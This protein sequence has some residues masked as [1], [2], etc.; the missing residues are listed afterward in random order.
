MSTRPNTRQKN[1]FYGPAAWRRLVAE[2]IE[3]HYGRKMPA[4]PPQFIAGAIASSDR[5]I[6]DPKV[7]FPWI[8]TARH[9]LAVEMESGGVYRAARERCPMLAIR[10]ISDIVGLK[11]ADA[12]TKYA[13]AAAAAFTRAYL[14][15]EPVNPK[16][17]VRKRSTNAYER[18]DLEAP[19]QEDLFLNMVKLDRLP[20]TVYVAP[21][22]C[23]TLKQ[24]WGI[25]REENQGHI[26][27]A[28][29]FHE[30]NIYSFENPEESG[31]SRIMD[32]S[33][34]ETWSVQELFNDP[35]K[36][37]LLVWLLKGA[38]RDDL[39]R[40]GV[41]FF[42]QDDV[43]AFMGF[44][45]EPDKSYTYDNL[46]LQSSITVVSHYET[47][48]KI[49]GKKHKYLRHLGFRPHFRKIDGTWFLEVTPTYVF[50]FDGKRKDFFHEQK[51]SGIKRIEGNR[52]VLSQVLLW[53]HV[54]CR[55]LQNR[56]LEFS[57]VPP[58]QVTQA[59]SDDELVSIDEV[60]VLEPP[61]AP[62]RKPEHPPEA[63]T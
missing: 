3:A 5:L 31:L 7:L 48:S 53:S 46:R 11:R 49:T 29:I 30:K 36:Q 10:G 57:K 27:N 20:E 38:L 32:E 39:Y 41:R 61:P 44:P 35:K 15:T 4:R 33:G 23:S 8:Q 2:K 58:F 37:R 28:W 45:D 12:W 40:L 34:L 43:Y 47:Q 56:W 14:R 59:V 52:A 19:K 25:L 26:S 1:I 6:K 18:G 13:C 17:V 54:L 24:A 16:T 42:P 51:L 50:T 21:A 22:L 55:K 9:L 60:K 62:R 63:E